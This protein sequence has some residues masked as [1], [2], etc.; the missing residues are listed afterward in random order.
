MQS[1]V[2][3]PGEEGVWRAIYIRGATMVDYQGTLMGGRAG[4]EISLF[5]AR[6]LCQALH[7]L[8]LYRM[9]K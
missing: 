6:A 1:R 3:G 5:D 2:L 9:E 4:W 8:S 7:S